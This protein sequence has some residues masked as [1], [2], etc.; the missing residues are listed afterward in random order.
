M[1]GRIHTREI[2]RK[3]TDCMRPLGWP[4]ILISIAGD[5]KAIPAQS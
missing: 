1:G 5:G 4:A 2:A 3:Q